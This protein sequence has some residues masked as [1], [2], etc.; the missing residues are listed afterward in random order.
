MLDF[1]VYFVYF[2]EGSCF[3]EFRM[4]LIHPIGSIQLLSVAVS[5]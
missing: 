1:I 4:G 5:C 2:V 3:V